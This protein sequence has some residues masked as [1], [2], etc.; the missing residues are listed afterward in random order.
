MQETETKY[1]K[2]E[3]KIVSDQP[4]ILRC[5]Y[6]EHEVQPGFIASANWHQGKLDN[7]KYHSA[8][9]YWARKIRPKNLI[10]FDS[11]NGAEAYGFKPSYYTK[12]RRRKGRKQ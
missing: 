2:P 8:D 10:V 12:D 1:I 6:C 4:L 7:K 5:V 11:A 9:S 3:Y